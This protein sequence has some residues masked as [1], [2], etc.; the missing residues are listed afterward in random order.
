MFVVIVA[1]LVLDKT[2]LSREALRV[3]FY[4]AALFAS[5]LVLVPLGFIVTVCIKVRVVKQSL[6]GS[7][8]R[9]KQAFRR[10]YVGLKTEEDV[11]DFKE[12]LDNL[13]T[14]L[15]GAELL[16]VLE[17]ARW[18]SAQ[19][20]TAVK[21]NDTANSEDQTEM[22]KRTSPPQEQLLP[23]TSMQLNVK[24]RFNSPVSAG[25]QEGS[26]SA[27]DQYYSKFDGAS[28][29]PHDHHPVYCT[30]FASF[31]NEANLMLLLTQSQVDSKVRLPI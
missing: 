7:A 4:D 28:C 24:S 21:A 30:L 9:S 31:S 8:E 13:R 14:Q 27:K 12:Y 3:E 29:Q 1:A 18:R 26:P 11:E 15:A 23:P 19:T 20:G 6:Y 22:H 2:D 10:L 5:F 17:G 16:S 25:E